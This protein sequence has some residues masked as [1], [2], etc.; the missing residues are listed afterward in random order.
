MAEYPN[1]KGS[2]KML[3]L[4]VLTERPVAIPIPKRTTTSTRAA[5]P[6]FALI[7][8]AVVK[9]SIQNISM[10]KNGVI[11]MFLYNDNMP[12]LV[13]SKISGDVSYTAEAGP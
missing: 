5:I 8:P 6:N 10:N 3:K 12:P 1:T 9:L 13:T 7:I 2:M 4:A 11:M